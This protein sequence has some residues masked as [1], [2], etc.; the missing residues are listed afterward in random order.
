MCGDK[1]LKTVQQYIYLGILL[2]EHLDYNAM[3]SHVSKAANRA[4]GLVIAKSKSFG[5]LPFS[6][7]TKLFDSMVWSVV[8]YG[9]AVWGSRQFNCINLIQLRAA[10]MGRYTPNTA[11]MGD[12]GWKPTIIRQWE[13]VIRQWPRMKS[14][15][16]DRINRKIF[17]WSEANAN[18]R[19]QNWN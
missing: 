4:L 19:C 1:C 6:S 2:S 5:G 10:L 14:M 17:D 7:F 12:T 9:V 13:A 11:V 16:S 8:N 18:G 3:A 15:G